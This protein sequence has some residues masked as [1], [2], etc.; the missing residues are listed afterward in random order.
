M[1]VTCNI[2]GTFVSLTLSNLAANILWP[3]RTHLPRYQNNQ[4]N[5]YYHFFAGIYEYIVIRP[6]D[7]S[8]KSLQFYPWTFFSFLSIYLAQQPHSGWPSN[9]FRMFG[10]RESFNN[11]YRDLAHPY[12]IF[13]GGGSKSAKFGVVCN[14]THIWASRVWK[15]GK[16]SER[17]NKLPV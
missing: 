12:L 13:T 5:A 9:V 14:I 1:P 11:W 8:R 2:I 15:C 16:M 4:N 17:W 10:R 6:P 3:W 7:V